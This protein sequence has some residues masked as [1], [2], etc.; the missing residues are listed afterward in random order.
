M[1]PAAPGNPSA[2][3]IHPRRS[4][5]RT[6]FCSTPPCWKPRTASRC[7]SRSG[8]APGRV[9]VWRW[10]LGQSSSAAR[11]S[12]RVV[13][14]PHLGQPAALLPRCRS[15]TRTTLA[16]HRT[17]P[18]LATP[19]TARKRSGTPACGACPVSAAAGACC[20]AGVCAAAA[21]VVGA[22]LCHPPPPAPA[23]YVLQVLGLEFTMVRHAD[24]AAAGLLHAQ[25]AWAA[26]AA[27]C[28]CWLPEHLHGA[29]LLPHTH[30]RRTWA[31]MEVAAC[32]SRWWRRLR[33]PTRATGR[34]FPSGCTP[35]GWTR[36]P[37][38]CRSWSALQVGGA[39]ALRSRAAV[40]AALCR[41][42]AACAAAALPSHGLPCPGPLRPLPI[43]HQT[44]R[45]VL[46]M[47]TGSP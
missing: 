2:P 41:F 17:A 43:S 33:R 26:A 22:D 21:G 37:R 5:G 39:A 38:A 10:V 25:H 6:T 40:L 4:C 46:T 35:P 8:S 28:A 1:L 29:L 13:H 30:K 11:P 18:G 7:P 12:P 32:M 14:Q 47:C 34:P 31:F 19:K 36:T 45:L 16:S 9:S 24:G 27:R 15:Q 20:A 23:V 42:R 44:T 3:P